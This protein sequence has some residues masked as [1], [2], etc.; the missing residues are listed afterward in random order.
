[1]KKKLLSVL[2]V[3][4]LALTVVTLAACNNDELK[5][6]I[7]DNDAKAQTAVEE[8]AK[9]AADELEAAKTALNALITAGDKTNTDALTAA[10]AT[11]NETIDTAEAAAVTADAA[12]K[13][14]LETAIAAAKA[15]AAAAVAALKTELEAALADAVAALEAADKADADALTAAVAKLNTAIDAAKTA[16]TAADATLKAELELSIKAANDAIAALKAD[17]EAALAEAVAALEAA[18][19]ADAEALTVAVADLNAAIDAAEA[20]A[21]AADATLKADLEKAI[22]DAIAA[23]KAETAAN[24]AAAVATLEAADAADA[25]AL[26]DATAALNAAIDAAEAAANAADAALKADLEKAIAD[27]IAALKAE[28]AK[29][30]A[31][32]VAALEAAD[33]ADAKALADATA[34]LDAA[35]KAAETAAKNGDAALETALN[36]AKKE[37]NAA[38]ATLDTKVDGIKTDLQAKI[39]ALVEAT[40]ALAQG[41]VSVAEFTETVAALEAAIED[42]AEIAATNLSNEIAALTEYVDAADEAIKASYIEIKTWDEATETV[43][44][45]LLALDDLYDAFWN[46]YGE[47][48]GDLIYDKLDAIYDEATVR[49]YRAT[50]SAAAE[51][52]YNKAEAVFDAFSYIVDLM[53]EYDINHYYGDQ[54]DAMELAV[55]NALMAVIN[56]NYGVSLDEIKETFTATL[57]DTQTKSEV[58][59]DILTKEDTATEINASVTLDDEWT[60]ILADVADMLAA[61]DTLVDEWEDLAEVAAL[62]A[63][64]QA[65]YDFLADMK[66]EAD[67]LNTRV[68]ELIASITIYNKTNKDAYEALM[69]DIAAWYE[70]VGDANE[71]NT[72]MIDAEDAAALTAQYDELVAE[73]V[74]AAEELIAEMAPYITDYVYN[75]DHDALEAINA[76]QAKIVEWAKDVIARGFATSGKDAG[77]VEYAVSRSVLK[78]NRVYERANALEDAEAE[79]AELNSDIADL[80]ADLEALDFEKNYIKGEYKTRYD[81][82]VARYEAWV[83]TYFSAP[84]DVEMAEDNVNYTLVEHADYEALCAVYAEKI[85]PVLQNAEAL[86]EAIKNLEVPT[87][88]SKEDIVAANAAYTALLS[89]FADFKMD[90][91]DIIGMTVAEMNNKLNAAEKK[92]NELCA[93]V[94]EDYAELDVPTTET[95]TIYDEAKVEALNDWYKKYFNLDLAE[96]TFPAGK[97]YPLSATLTVDEAFYNTAKAVYDAY[98]ELDDAKA[99]EFEKLTTVINELCSQK[100]STELRGNITAAAA[101]IEAFNDGTNAPDGYADAQF[102]ATKGEAAEL[103]ADLDAFDAE[104]TDL[105]IRLGELRARI[106]ALTKEYTDLDDVA[107]RNDYSNVIIALEAD[108]AEFLID[109]NGYDEFTPDEYA[110]INNA[111]LVIVQGAAYETLTDD[112]YG[113]D[114]VKDY[115]DVIYDNAIKALEAVE[116]DEDD[117]YIVK[118]DEIVEVALTDYAN[119]RAMGAVYTAAIANAPATKVGD[120]MKALVNEYFD[121]AC[122]YIVENHTTDGAE[123]GYANACI[124]VL[125]HA[126]D[127]YV[128]FVAEYPALEDEATMTYARAIDVAILGTEN[129][130]ARITINNFETQ[131][132][133]EKAFIT[134]AFAEIEKPQ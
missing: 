10:I 19:A 101:L 132:E 40:D 53:T 74:A 18:D 91:K 48:M 45:K 124:E 11:L 111:K 42:A 61:E 77:E 24:L 29:N 25:K 58:I 110:T 116:Y 13:A 60:K 76:L 98:Y 28:T 44:E 78:F 50:T 97:E 115:I 120:D 20:A 130:N 129:V 37:L 7:A 4:V 102:A 56:A 17:L 88:M 22:A 49:L 123:F 121:A 83:E 66:A 96:D 125:K 59:Y 47:N 131:K 16:A 65:R 71:T 9:K 15:D 12:L 89:K 127:T 134:S 86:V 100:A 128:A 92:Y 57:D 26:A 27:A 38:I 81:D 52:I 33:A 32:A 104:V 41:K 36:N 103:T 62:Y 64:Y 54:Y 118:L 109:N 34:K 1:M 55:D 113:I 85:L 79:A 105:E 8:A 73:Y 84:Y 43:I 14:E 51:E 2:L 117:E 72:A 82:I 122:D 21:T 119:I 94:A 75:H 6:Q 30:L 69:A 39:D 31:D 23:L 68:E 108:I 5:A 95:V 114:A 35:V 112:A 46:K 126:I 90:S 93:S 67:A 133:T 63:D 70:A 106:V 107:D 87:V 80:Y 3:C 99:A